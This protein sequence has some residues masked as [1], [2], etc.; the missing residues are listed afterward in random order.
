MNPASIE[1]RAAVAAA[2]ARSRPRRHAAC[3]AA[4]SRVASAAARNRSPARTMSSASVAL[5]NAGTAAMAGHLPSGARGWVLGL[6]LAVV[7]LSGIDP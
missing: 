5:A 3:S 7:S 2:S 1:V 6:G 4:V